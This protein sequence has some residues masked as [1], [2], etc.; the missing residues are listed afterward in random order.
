[1]NAKT[2]GQFC[3]VAQA[4]EIVAERWTPLVLRELMCGSRRF[5]DLRKG[6]PLMSPS[7]LSKRLQFLED[8]GI[9]KRVAANAGAGSEYHLTSAGKELRPIIEMLGLW[10]HQWVK[11]SLRPDELDPALLMW[12]IRRCVQPAPAGVSR[13]AVVRF[14]LAGVPSSKSR[15]WLV[16]HQEEVDLCLKNPGHDVDL[17]VASHIRALVETWTGKL[18]LQVALRTKAIVLEGDRALARGFKDWF[19]LSTFTQLAAS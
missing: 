16:F 10:G 3:P 19:R 18:P 12:D 6:V 4:A 8:A 5:N 7:L 11:R 15:W 9:V 1:M 17:V 13:R 14:D 2:Y